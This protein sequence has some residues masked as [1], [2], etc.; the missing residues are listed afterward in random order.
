[1]SIKHPIER[2]KYNTWKWISDG[3]IAS[4]SELGRLW[5]T[6]RRS[7]QIDWFQCLCGVDLAAVPA[8]TTC[9]A[10][11]CCSSSSISLAAGARRSRSGRAGQFE[12]GFS[13]AS[14]ASPSAKAK[15]QSEQAWA[16]FESAQRG[17][18]PARHVSTIR[19]INKTITAQQ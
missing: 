16:Q 15:H 19:Q 2:Q 18:D 4:L 1:M 8:S 17:S 13:T 5:D 7:W 9:N 11:C 14:N 10:S 12:A 6:M 3:K